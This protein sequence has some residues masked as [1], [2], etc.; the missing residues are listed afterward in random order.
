MVEH[1]KPQPLAGVSQES[2]ID[3]IDN[4]DYLVVILVDTDC[5]SPVVCFDDAG[6]AVL[7][8]EETSIWR[9]DPSAGSCETSKRPGQSL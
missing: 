6:G 9:T 5:S 2:P 8:T 7:R 4:L 3:S 1:R